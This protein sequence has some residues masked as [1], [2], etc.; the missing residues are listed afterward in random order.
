MMTEEADFPNAQGGPQALNE[1]SL[2]LRRC[3]IERGSSVKSLPMLR[4]SP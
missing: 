4:G 1:G 2:A 3:M